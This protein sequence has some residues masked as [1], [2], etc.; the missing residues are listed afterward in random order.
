MKGD[1]E[2]VRNSPYPARMDHL[3][4]CVLLGHWV[5]LDRVQV[6]AVASLLPSYRGMYCDA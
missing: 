5:C 4:L 2:D 3:W 1:I 6:E